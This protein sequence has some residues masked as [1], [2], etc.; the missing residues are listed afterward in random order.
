MCDVVAIEGNIGSAKTTLTR[1]LARSVTVLEEPIGTWI[2][3]LRE[4]YDRPSSQ[5]AFDLQMEIMRSRVEHVAAACRRP[6]NVAYG[7]NTGHTTVVSER[8]TES[9]KDVFMRMLVDDGVV[10]ERHAAM[11]RSWGETVDAVAT[12][13][14]RLVGVVYLDVCPEVCMK[15]AATR[16][17]ERD[18]ETSLS[19]DYVRRLD[20]AYSRW[21]TDLEGQ[22]VP[23][24]I[25][26]VTGTPLETDVDEF[27]DAGVRLVHD[28]LRRVSVSGFLSPSSAQHDL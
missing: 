12:P 25:L 16:A 4:F 8:C 18:S 22:G 20:E 14:T 2:P 19:L 7:T 26:R 28:M 21:L 10:N 11:Y 13:R 3:F 15:R 17:R 9:S 6:S 23:V 1:A 27:V 5:S 24:S